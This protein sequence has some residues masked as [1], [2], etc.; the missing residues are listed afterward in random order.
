MMKTTILDLVTTRLGIGVDRVEISIDCEII[1][2]KTKIDTGNKGG[3]P[4]PTLKVI[5]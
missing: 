4:E 3:R 5:G 1:W 2:M